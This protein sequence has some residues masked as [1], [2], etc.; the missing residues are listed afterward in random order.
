M[1]LRFKAR[2]H[3]V[4]VRQPHIYPR[5]IVTDGT[6]LQILK[7]KMQHN[8]LRPSSPAFVRCRNHDIAFTFL[9]P[10]PAC[11]VHQKVLV[12]TFGR[13]HVISPHGKAADTHVQKPRQFQKQ[14]KN[15]SK[16]AV[17]AV[18]LNGRRQALVPKAPTAP[19]AI[20]RVGPHDFRQS[21]CKVRASTPPQQKKAP[22]CA[23]AFPFT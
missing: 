15:S 19:F 18:V 1:V 20:F 6:Q 13:R 9:D 2:H 7:D 10:V 14:V 21:T 22:A 4:E 5:R 3:F 23:D 17:T 12:S 11:A 16:L 8:I